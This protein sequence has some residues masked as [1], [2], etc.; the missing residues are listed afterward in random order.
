MITKSDLNQIRNVVREEITAV[1][2]RLNSKINNVSKEIQKV[3]DKLVEVSVALSDE[4]EKL[5]SRVTR[6]ESHLDL[7]TLH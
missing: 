1:E 5:T 2:E 6:I 3:H 4:D 7:K